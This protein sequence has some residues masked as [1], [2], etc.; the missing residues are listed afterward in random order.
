MP[1]EGLKKA[2]VTI[3]AQGTLDHAVIAEKLLID[4]HYYA[5]ANKAS[6]T[7]PKDLNPPQPST[8]SNRA[9][10]MQNDS[11][12]SSHVAQSLGCSRSF[13]P[14]FWHKGAKDA[15]FLTSRIDREA[16]HDD[17]RVGLVVWKTV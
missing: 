1:T 15:L 6:L 16:V 17:P 12:V 7:K 14:R 5:I 13:M 10:K 8:P 4:N 2:G 9:A 3:T 11:A